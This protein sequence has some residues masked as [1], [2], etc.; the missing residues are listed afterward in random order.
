MPDRLVKRDS[1]QF[2]RKWVSDYWK[3]GIPSPHIPHP[4]CPDF[5]D[6]EDISKIQSKIRKVIVIIRLD[7][8]SLPL[9]SRERARVRGLHADFPPFLP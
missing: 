6:R 1:R 7:L 9:P 4:V 3:R 2:K 5:P 8:I